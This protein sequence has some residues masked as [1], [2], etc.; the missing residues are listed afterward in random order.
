MWSA[1]RQST[2]IQ[3]TFTRPLFHDH[4][5]P[6]IPRC[7]PH[8]RAV[9]RGA[10]VLADEG[11]AVAPRLVDFLR[12][13]LLEVGLAG[14]EAIHVGGGVAG[15][16]IAVVEAAYEAELIVCETAGDGEIV[17]AAPAQ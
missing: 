17:G 4:L 9:P 14:D 3:T 2:T 11:F 7:A 13:A 1:R 15:T 16:P 5:H 12:G 8:R 6:G 10:G